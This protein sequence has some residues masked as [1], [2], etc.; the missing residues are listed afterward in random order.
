M[1][2]LPA[3]DMWSAG[4]IL[5]FFLAGKFPLFQSNDD[6]EALLEIACIIGRRRMEKVA[7]LHCERLQKP[8][9]AVILIGSYSSNIHHKYSIDNT[10]RKTLARIRRDAESEATGADEG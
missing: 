3:I 2:V 8:V 4:M 7:T 1:C 10:R 6:V 9:G 5:L